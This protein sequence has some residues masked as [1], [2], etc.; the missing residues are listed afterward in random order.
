ME[1]SSKFENLIGRGRELWATDEEFEQFLQ[2]IKEAR[3][4]K[5]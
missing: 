2:I 1:E 5:G 3:A 4:E